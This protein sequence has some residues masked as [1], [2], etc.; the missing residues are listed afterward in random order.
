MKKEWILWNV[1]Q[2][3]ENITAD[4]RMEQI[5][6]KNYYWSYKALLQIFFLFIVLWPGIMTLFQSYLGES[7]SFDVLLR[8]AILQIIVII[9]SGRFLYSCYFGNQEFYDRSKGRTSYLVIGL[10][11]AAISWIMLW[12]ERGFRHPLPWIMMGVGLLI[13]WGLCHLA[14]LHHAMLMDETTEEAGH[15]SERWIPGVCGVTLAAYFLVVNVLMCTAITGGRSMSHLT[16][17]EQCM[18]NTVQ[19]GIS[20]YY[21]L[22]SYR[23]DYTFKTDTQPEAPVYDENNSYDLSHVY[24]LANDGELYNQILNPGNDKSIYREYHR[25]AENHFSWEMAYEGR[26]I[27]D[28]EWA[29]LWTENQEEPEFWINEPYTGL[30]DID[31]KSVTSVT[32]EYQNQNTCY[33]I[34]YN[35]DYDTV[36]TTLKDNED[37][38]NFTATDC[39]T[40]NEYNTLIQYERTETGITKATEEPRTLQRTITILGVDREQIQSEIRTL[41][42]RYTP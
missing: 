37:L 10:Q 40:L 1:L 5:E 34:T 23:M 8:L 3:P 36:G 32:K 27:S 38:K 39:Y 9:E 18:I 22:S 35:Q 14:Y 26:W 13:Y 24:C 42:S 17:E 7:F 41:T 31:P 20:N 16:E 2:N 29:E 4:E 19:L 11:I 28:I 12:I 6:W 33:T 30:P 15:K 25:E 21:A